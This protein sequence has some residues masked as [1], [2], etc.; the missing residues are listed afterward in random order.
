MKIVQMCLKLETKNDSSFPAEIT[1]SKNK[2]LEREEARHL[3]RHCKVL[4][5][6]TL[7]GNFMNH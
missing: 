7:M 5:H 4:K 3:Q 1:P 6:Q 2:N